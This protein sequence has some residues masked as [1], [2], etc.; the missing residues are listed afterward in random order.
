MKKNILYKLPA[1]ALCS[2][3][4]F[5]CKKQHKDVLVPYP[6]DITFEEQTLDRFSFKIPDAPFKAGDNQSGFVTVNVKK[7]PDGS[8]SGFALSN[9]NW[10]SYPWNLS[11]DF[12]EQSSLTQQQI[13]ASIDSTI[14]S[15]YTTRPN[16]TLNYLVGCVKDDD[17]SITLDKPS[18]VEHI[19]V[20]N[21]TYNY[22]LETYG[23]VFSGTLNSATQE[24][25]LSGTKVRNV[26]NPNTSTAMYGRFTLPG[27][28]GTNLIRLAGVEIL[29]KRA[30]GKTAADAARSAG[31]TPSQVAAD[32]TAAA[33]A[34]SQ[35]YVKLTV[36]GVKGG[37]VA[38][39]VDYYLAIRPKVDPANPTLNYIAPDWFKVDLTS[40]GTV[41]KLVFHLSSSYQDINGN[42]LVP[43]YFCLDG[44]RLKK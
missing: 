23:S 17:A 19:L 43:P 27:P 41:E 31:K 30:A 14:F 26:Q 18:V 36:D 32:S 35:G 1:I 3:L 11:P 10:R 25:S 21:T 39:S 29:A 15:V 9:K 7:N 28:G 6:E 33:N 34:L 37:T 24:Y 20:A 22:L 5:S 38:G 4:F 16:H 42:M 44:I 2:L 12:V 13:K 8:F 40:L